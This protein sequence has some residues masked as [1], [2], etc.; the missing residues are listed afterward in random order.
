MQNKVEGG[1]FLSVM[2]RQGATVLKLFARKDKAV[3]VKTQEDS[4]C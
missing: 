1:F 3:L 4:E 2:V